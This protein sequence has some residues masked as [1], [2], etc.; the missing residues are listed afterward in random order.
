MAINTVYP[1]QIHQQEIN[2]KAVFKFGFNPSCDTNNQ[3]IWDGGGI[4]SYISEA[5][6]LKVSSADDGDTS[7][8]QIFGLDENW[9]E[10]NETIT[11]T[12]QTAV[13]TQN[14]YIR[15][16]R[17]AVLSNSPAG[18]IYAGTGTVTSGVPANI[19]M[20]ITAGENQ[21]LMATWTVPAG[22]TAY[23]YQVTISSG[24][25]NAN[26]YITGRLKIRDYGQVFRTRIVVTLNNTIGIFDKAYPTVIGEKSDIELQAISSSGTDAVSGTFTA[27]YVKNQ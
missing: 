8:I 3:T 1:I 4:Y 27:I 21:T 17:G 7:T 9:N 2:H 23:L 13:T 20:R 24:T 25:S 5:T 6:E 22:Y 18:N 10:V 11:I 14:K 19:Y 12:G 15:I 16:F 26:K